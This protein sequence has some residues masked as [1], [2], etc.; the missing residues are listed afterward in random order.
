MPIAYRP[1]GWCNTP[2]KLVDCNLIKSIT[3]EFS[4]SFEVSGYQPTG[5]DNTRCDGGGGASGSKTWTRI[6]YDAATSGAVPEGCFMLA[7]GGNNCCA[8][9][10][11]VIFVAGQVVPGTGNSFS[12]ATTGPN[13]LG[14]TFSC[15]TEVSPGGS[16]YPNPTMGSDGGAQLSMTDYYGGF[17][18]PL[19]MS[20]FVGGSA[21]GGSFSS[22]FN[23]TFGASIASEGAFVGVHTFNDT[24]S[25]WTLNATVAIA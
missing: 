19:T 6:P 11:L 16:S 15:S 7:R 18:P 2:L 8:F 1:P 4:V 9:Q 14:A 20:V 21:A 22:S 12:V 23:Q 3:L 13:G 25:G 5:W 24:G 10:P 17:E